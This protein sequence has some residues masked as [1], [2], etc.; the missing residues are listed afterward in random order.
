M[1]EN[2]Q[3]LK[4]LILIISLI[5]AGCATSMTTA[6][7]NS[8]N[9]VNLVGTWAGERD[10]D[11]KCA[12]GSWETTRDE[13]GSYVVNFYSDPERTQFTGREYGYWWTKRGVIYFLAPRHDT[14]P[15]LY[16][17]DVQP[18]GKTAVFV[19]KSGDKSSAC[20][21]NYKFQDNKLDS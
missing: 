4:Y 8:Q 17:Y 12:Y 11:A 10:I 2:E 19:S 14:K 3:I 13:G 1:P 16:T 18:G 5:T 7:Q 9:D 6:P 21:S 20:G 15:D